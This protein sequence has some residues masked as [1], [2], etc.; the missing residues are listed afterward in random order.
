MTEWVPVADLAE[1]AGR[2]RKLVNVDGEPIALF[3]IGDEVFALHDTCIHKQRSLSKGVLLNGHI[4]CPG[5]QWAFDPRTGYAPEQGEC[6]PSYRVMVSDGRVFID[7]QQR[8][9]VH[10]YDG[11]GSV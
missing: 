11:I 5:H 7:P 2:R 3:R 10:D 8:V 4:I 1:L 9:L 6:Q